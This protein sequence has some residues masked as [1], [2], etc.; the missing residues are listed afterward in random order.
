MTEALHEPLA[1]PEVVRLS[2]ARHDDA[3]GSFAETWSARALA[4]AGI[5]AAFVQDNESVSTRGVL[6]GLH[7]QRPS[8]QGKLV[9]VVVGDVYDVAVDLR[10]A[11]PSF[12]RWVGLTLSDARPE[13]LW[14]PAGFAHGFL[15]LSERSIVAYK[16]DAPYVPGAERVLAWDD[17]TV[18]IQWPL[19]PGVAPVL[20]ERDARGE[21]LGRF[22]G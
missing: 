3:R 21:A 1:L 9:R 7:L 20:S 16:V 22:G 6:R 19:A 5:R 4:A 8:A 18:G 11:S 15:T 12:G 2:L 13:A 17:P 10:P 14:I